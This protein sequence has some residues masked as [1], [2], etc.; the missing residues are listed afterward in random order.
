MGAL[1]A[2]TYL[3]KSGDTS[4]SSS[5]IIACLASFIH[6]YNVKMHYV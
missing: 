3:K 4:K 1:Y 5:N 2:C 6:T